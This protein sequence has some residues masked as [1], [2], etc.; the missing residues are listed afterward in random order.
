MTPELTLNMQSVNQNKL[1]GL[2]HP[3]HLDESTS[4]LRGIS[5]NFY[6]LFGRKT[7]SRVLNQYPYVWLKMTKNQCVDVSCNFLSNFEQFSL[8]LFDSLQLESGIIIWQ[9]YFSFI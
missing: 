5:D 2:S 6:F 8:H 4:I 3:N 7:I 1:N 9:N